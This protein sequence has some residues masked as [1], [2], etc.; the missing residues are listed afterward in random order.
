M[1]TSI[2]RRSSIETE[3]VVCDEQLRNLAGQ[4]TTPNRFG[5]DSG[6]PIPVGRFEG[7]I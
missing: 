4:S 2:P 6:L 5:V 7:T 1:K 3:S